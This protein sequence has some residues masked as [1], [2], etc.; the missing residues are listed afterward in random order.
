MGKYWRVRSISQA[1][2]DSIRRCLARGDYNPLAKGL[3]KKVLKLSDKEITDLFL[4][5][6][7]DSFGVYAA[8]QRLWDN[9][10]KRTYYIN[11]DI[12]SWL[13]GCKYDY[14]GNFIM[15]SRPFGNVAYFSFEK[16]TELRSALCLF[17]GFDW[18]SKDAVLFYESKDSN[19]TNMYIITVSHAVGDCF[20]EHGIIS[21]LALDK[22]KDR[23][24]NTIKKYADCILKLATYVKAFPEAIH[25]GPPYP[26]EKD[27]SIRQFTIGPPKDKSI[28][29]EHGSPCAHWRRG[30]FRTLRDER[31]KRSPDGCPKIIFVRDCIVAQKDHEIYTVEDPS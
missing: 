24:P 20:A 4:E 15:D 6:G 7:S 14:A 30:H 16:G 27:R 18:I 31:F 5:K 2:R 8:C 13:D 12:V 29:G 11:R 21:P 22:Y 25:P 17:G 10:K 19:K 3:H 9:S 1:Y 26:D 23:M 28:I